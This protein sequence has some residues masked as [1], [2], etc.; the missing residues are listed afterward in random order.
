LRLWGFAVRQIHLQ[1]Y[2]DTI[3]ITIKMKTTNLQLRDYQAISEF[4]YQIRRFLA[5]SERAAA[6]AGLEPQQ[7]Q[8][9][10]AIRGVPA[11]RKVRIADLAERLQIRHHSA[12]ELVDRMAVKGL[13]QRIQGE[14]D[15]REVM[16]RLTDRGSRILRALT[17]IHKDELRRAAPLLVAA[18]GN[19][20]APK[21][22]HSRPAKA[23]K[24]RV[25]KQERPGAG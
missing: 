5:F 7:H 12:A 16:V 2:R 24:R 8:L 9:L 14:E 15:R 4:R 21:R 10:L 3:Y 22:T 20:T 23:A 17:V 6:G 18:L 11:D 19:L 13:V 25:F 1:I